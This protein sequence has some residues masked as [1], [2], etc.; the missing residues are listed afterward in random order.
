GGASMQLPGAEGTRQVPLDPWLAGEL[1]GFIASYGVQGTEPAGTGL[2][3]LLAE[4]EEGAAASRRPRADPAEPIPEVAGALGG[5]L[6]PFQWAG[7]RYALDARQ[8][9][10]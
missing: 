2:G 7:V 1:D 6:A 5:S 3:R 4:R 9:F 8:M 10:L